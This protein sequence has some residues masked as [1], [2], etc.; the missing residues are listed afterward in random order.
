MKTCMTYGCKWQYDVTK[1]GDSYKCPECEKT[2][3]LE[4]RVEYG[5]GHNCYDTDVEN[6]KANCWQLWELKKNI[7]FMSRYAIHEY[8]GPKLR[9]AER[10]HVVRNFNKN[11]IIGRKELNKDISQYNRNG[12]SKVM[13]EALRKFK[14]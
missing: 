5:V 9:T 3:C 8:A 10:Q 7:L 1:V 4:C 14:T 12:N 13:H 6:R 2:Y 11:H